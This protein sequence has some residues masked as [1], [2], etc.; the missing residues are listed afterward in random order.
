MRATVFVAL[1]AGCAAFVPASPQNFPPVL[2]A[3]APRAS[4]HSPARAPALAGLRATATVPAPSGLAARV[5]ERLA[6]SAEVAISKIF[7]AGAG[8]QTASLVAG[9]NFGFACDSLAFFASVGLGDLLGVFIGHTLFQLLKKK[10]AGDKTVQMTQQVQVAA[11]LG[12]AA[13]FSGSMWQLALNAMLK[14][15][16]GFNGTFLGVGVACTWA[17]FAG[18][19]VWRR[20]LSPIMGAVQKKNYPNLKSDVQLSI[21]IGAAT[22]FF[23]GTDISFGAANWLAGIV[24]ITAS[25][26]DLV[27]VCIA[28]ISTSLGFMAAQLVMAVMLPADKCWIDPAPKFSN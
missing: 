21:A 4:L 14:L 12:G 25:M 6:S 3:G 22:A 7:P 19:R 15:E 2:A 20:L 8:W 24:G 28:G 17:F 27:G 9:N 10:M 16:L 11:L 23:V 13:F 26:S 5:S 18:L 1:I